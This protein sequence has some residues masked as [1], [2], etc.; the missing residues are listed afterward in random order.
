MATAYYET[1]IVLKVDGVNYGGVL[2]KVCGTL[3]A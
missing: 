2:R 3:A 1:V